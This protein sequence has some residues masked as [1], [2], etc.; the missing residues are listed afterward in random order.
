MYSAD[1]LITLDSKHIDR[2][3]IKNVIKS[4]KII[5]IILFNVYEI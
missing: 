4:S 5:V 3:T 1:H 2:Y